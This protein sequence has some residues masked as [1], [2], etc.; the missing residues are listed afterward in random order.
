MLALVQ[1]VVVLGVTLTAAR[2]SPSRALLV[3]A[4]V[5]VLI[6][7]DLHLPTGFTSDVTATRMVALGAAVGLLRTRRGD[8]IRATPLHLAAG[9]YAVTTGVT[10]V[11]LAGPELPASRTF[12]AWLDLLDPLLVG[13][14]A[15]ACARAA[16]PRASLQALGAVAAVALAGGALEHLT[17]DSLARLLVKTRGLEVRADQTRVRVGSDF[18]LAFAWTVAAL[19]P[20]LVALLR[21]RLPIALFGLAASLVVAYWTFTRSVPVG[22]ALGLVV[23]VVGLRDRRTAALVLIAAVGLGLTVVTVPS[24]RERF[25]AG[26]DQGALNVRSERAPVVLDAA[27]RHPLAGLGLTGVVAI[28]VPE[29]DNSFLLTYAE[30]GVVGIVTLLVVLGCGL[31]LVGRGLRGPPSDGRTTATVALGGALTMVAGGTA[32]DAFSV[33]G[34]ATLLALV[35][36]VGMAAAEDVAGPAPIARPLR[37]APDLRVLLVGL[38]VGIGLV[39]NSQ[40]GSHL[41]ENAT[42]S[43]FSAQ[44]LVP[45][46]DQVDRGRV[47]IAAVCAAAK[48]DPPSGVK[49]GCRDSNTGAGVGSFRLEAA[50]RHRLDAALYTLVT[51]VR[52]RTLIPH[53]SAI[54]LPPPRLGVSTWQQTAPWSAG[55]VALLLALLV[56]TEPLR[57]FQ[58]RTRGWDWTVDRRDV[59]PGHGGLGDPPG[60]IRQERLQRG[61]EPL[62][63]AG[64]DAVGRDS[65]R[66]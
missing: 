59:P 53:L 3:L 14:V 8:V 9:L 25:T 61:A 1:V 11:L 32:F 4:G 56:P 42:F 30:T 47:L 43:T 58:A 24:V 6:P 49:V 50:D 16:G 34:T 65:L 44:D 21:R 26:V 37:D 38:S 23:L 35:L 15:L 52:A 22:F 17:G 63:R 60:G 64:F 46:F 36:A 19:T 41:V 57:R 13:A 55:L 12:N 20:A 51:T 66:A 48:A 45:D 62:Q 29:T 10:G 28:G 7:S 2:L 31:V 18:A 5:V 40:A 39:V 33:R 27:S 54:P